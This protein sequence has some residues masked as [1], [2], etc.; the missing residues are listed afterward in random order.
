MFGLLACYMMSHVKIT[1]RDNITG[2]ICSGLFVIYLLWYTY[3]KPKNEY[4]S[5]IPLFLYVIG[6]YVIHWDSICEVTNVLWNGI[7]G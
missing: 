5:S 1:V 4:L 6:Y 7:F 2:I 3:P